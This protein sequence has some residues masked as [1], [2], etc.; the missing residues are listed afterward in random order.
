MCRGARGSRNCAEWFTNAAAARKVHNM[1]LTKYET[2]ITVGS[3][4]TQDTLSPLSLINDLGAASCNELFSRTVYLAHA[5]V[6]NQ[7]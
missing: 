1:L 5:F 6:R 3:R 7:L 2:N 4:V